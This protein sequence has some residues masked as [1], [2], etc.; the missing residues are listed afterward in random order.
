MTE[1]R[2]DGR[3]T[4]ADWC[5]DPAH[6]GKCLDRLFERVGSS[7]LCGVVIGQE[8]FIGA[9]LFKTCQERRPCPI[10]NDGQES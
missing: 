1:R 7:D 5:R 2:Y 8:R 4:H 9:G 10:H 6:E 3:T